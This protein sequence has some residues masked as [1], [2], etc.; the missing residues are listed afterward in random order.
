MRLDYFVLLAIAGFLAGVD[1]ASVASPGLSTAT[2]SIASDQEDAGVQRFLKALKEPTTTK[3]GNTELS[4]RSRVLSKPGSRG[5]N[6][7]T[8]CSRDSA[9]TTRRA[10][11][12]VS[13]R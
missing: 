2:H 10:S 9:S 4:R 5:L 1:A 3:R 12:L 8:I 11:C 6:T 13:L 7:S